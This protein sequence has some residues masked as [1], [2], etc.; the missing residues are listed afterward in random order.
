MSCFK[1]ELLKWNEM[2]DIKRV[3]HQ[4]KYYDSPNGKYVVLECYDFWVIKE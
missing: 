4:F 2:L 1:T 3:S